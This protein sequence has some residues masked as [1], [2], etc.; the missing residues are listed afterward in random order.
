MILAEKISKLRKQLGWSQEELAEKLDVSRQSISKWESN[1]SIPEL[2]KIIKLAEV[3]E[4]S[5]DFLLK[6]EHDMVQIEHVPSRVKDH[7]VSLDQAEHYIQTKINVADFTSKGVI[8][9][10]CSPAP[11]LFF[12]AMAQTDRLGLSFDSAN[13]LGVI[14]V[15]VMV[16]LGI[17]NFLKTNQFKKT[18]DA[19][20]QNSFELAYGVHSII[21]DKME[22]FQARYSTQLSLGIFL[23]IAS[24]I[25]SM[26]AII[27]FN[28]VDILLL[29]IIAL[30]FIVALGIFV[31]SPVAAKQQAFDKL[32]EEN[33]AN[34]KEY[35]RNQRFTKL[36]AFYWPLLIAIFL[37]WSLWT[38]NWGVTW[39]IWPVG[40]LLFATLIGLMELLHKEPA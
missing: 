4:V 33:K 1:I 6:D 20:E 40:A 38:M 11:L 30:L 31:I 12:L 35:L 3:F 18:V 39:I 17:N 36:A 16:A 19:I 9:C 27:F 13:L 29:T 24:F 26:V 10:I 22:K 25:P 14:G 34:S 15:V 23:F 5:T 32:V 7:Q 2:N 37:G 28:G 8:L 21:Q